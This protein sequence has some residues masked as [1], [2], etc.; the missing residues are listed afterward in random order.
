MKEETMR[1]IDKI[2]EQFPEDRFILFDGF[3]DAVIGFDPYKFR[4]IYSIDKCVEI[5]VERDEMTPDEAIEFFEYNVAGTLLGE[6]TPIWFDDLYA[7]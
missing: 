4:V 5:L 1:V 3:D 2:I 7:Y 6:D